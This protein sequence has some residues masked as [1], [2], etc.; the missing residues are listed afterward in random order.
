MTTDWL[1]AAE[2]AARLGGRIL[3]DWR[4]RIT[5]TEKGRADL[6]TEADFASQQAIHDLLHE[7]FPGH[8][9]LGEEGLARTYDDDCPYRW[10]IDPLD[11]TGNYV[12]GFPYFAVSIALEERGRLI[13]GVVY[14]PTRDE[15]FAAGPDRPTTLN[16]SPV[17]PSVVSSLSGAM[18]VASLPVGTTRDDPAV[19]RFLDVLPL[20]QSLQRTGSA[21]LNL[22]YVACG[23]IDGFWSSSLKPWD[24]AAGHV[25]VERAGGKVTRADG[26]PVDVAVPD[27]VATNGTAL[28]EELCGLLT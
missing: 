9:F 1:E 4:S 26:R 17:R 25:L 14:D 19:R 24:M 18:A 13:V 2:R 15:L 3:L 11:G 16:G 5:V 6:V 27:I 12:H 10:I 28:H 7:A 21:A 20:A 8:G 23:R 22:A